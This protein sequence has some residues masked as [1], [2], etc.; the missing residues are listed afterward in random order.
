MRKKDLFQLA[1][2][3]IKNKTNK[4]VIAA[5]TFG[6]IML[7]EVIWLLFA[8][9]LHFRSQIDNNPVNNLFALASNSIESIDIRGDKS[10]EFF[11]SYKGHQLTFEQK[12]S[13]DVDDEVIWSEIEL[14]V[15]DC[16]RFDTNINFTID[17][18][19]QELNNDILF[20][21]LKT[22]STHPQSV[23]DYL[24]SSVGHGAIYGEGF[25]DSKQEIY[26]SQKLLDELGIDKDVA[27][28][29]L[30][31]FSLTYNDVKYYSWTIPDNDNIFDNNHAMSIDKDYKLCLNGEVKIFKDFKIVGVI[32]REY[33]EINDVTKNDADIWFKDDVLKTQDGIS[34]FP[35]LSVQEMNSGFGGAVVCTYP[36]ADYVG[37]S[38]QVAEQGCFF[39]FFSAGLNYAATRTLPYSENYFMPTEISCVQCNSFKESKKLVDKVENTCAYNGGS[40]LRSYLIFSQEYLYFRDI[41]KIFNTISL[42]LGIIGGITLLTVSLNYGNIIAFNVRKRKDFLSMMRKM[43]ITEKDENSLCRMEIFGGYVISAVIAFFVGFLI[44]AIVKA[45]VKSIIKEVELLAGLN[46]ALWTYLPAF[47]LVGV[48][49]LAIVGMFPISVYVNNKER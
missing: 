49:M 22:K 43:G 41:S 47:L 24:L 13:L 45:I 20:K 3:R 28:G 32:G 10:K 26:V 36:S 25:G 18:K 37:Y 42:V 27:L 30:V 9:N 8:F 39:P 35:K 16:K 4:K 7:V 46:I 6:I 11:D 1:W 40:N 5:M 29:K 21:F 38:N 19:A 34:L 31:S 14:I 44:A 15:K 2:L 12:R 23:E 33:Y 48:V 17:N